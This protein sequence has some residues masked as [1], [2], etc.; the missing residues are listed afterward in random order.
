MLSSKRS[1]SQCFQWQSQQN[2]IKIN[3]RKLSARLQTEEVGLCE[4]QCA[5]RDV[6]SCFTEF[7]VFVCGG[8]RFLE[9][10]YFGSENSADIQ[11]TG[12]VTAVSARLKQTA[13]LRILLA[14]SIPTMCTQSTS[15]ESS[16]YKHGLTHNVKT[17]R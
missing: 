6:S 7:A 14:W 4:Q 17:A 3:I 13:W 10:L 2:A 15:N 9:E 1:T 5:V 11:V 12:H 16:Y 8:R